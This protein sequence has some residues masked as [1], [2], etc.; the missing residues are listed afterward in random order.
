MG[1]PVILL[2]PYS[3]ARFYVTGVTDGLTKPSPLYET[4]GSTPEE[5]HEKYAKF[6][7]NFDEQEDFYFDNMENPAG[8]ELFRRKLR[9]YKSRLMPRRKGRIKHSAFVSQ[10]NN[11]QSFT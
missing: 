6:L 8:D 1:D 3:S 4:F 7:L 9:S 5:K 10:L 11:H 2:Y